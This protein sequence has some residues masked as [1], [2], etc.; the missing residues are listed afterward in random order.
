MKERVKQA[1]NGE[2]ELAILEYDKGNYERSFS[3]LER[4]HI[5]GQSFTIAHTK[6]HWWML[7]IAIKTNNFKEILGQITRIIASIVF[8]RI[9]VPRGNT[10][11]ANVS[12]IKPMPIPEDLKKILESKT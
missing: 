11:G 12:P 3:H 10:G 7:K 5:L 6:S 2:V 4:A 8:S 1:F 9:W